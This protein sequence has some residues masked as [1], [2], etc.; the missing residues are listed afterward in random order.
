MDEPESGKRR[1][2]RADKGEDA[3]KGPK[4]KVSLCLSEETY[5]RLAIHAVGT[6]RDMSAVAEELFTVNLRRYVLQDRGGAPVVNTEGPANPEV[7]GL[8]ST[9]ALTPPD[10]ASGALEPGKGR[11]RGGR[12]RPAA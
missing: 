2:R 10:D 5:R 3:V 9:E 1:R 6:G 11:G 4:R 12:G 7:E 8:P